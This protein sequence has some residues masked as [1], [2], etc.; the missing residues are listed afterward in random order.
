MTAHALPEDREMCLKSGL[1]D[2]L[3]KPVAKVDLLAALER[4]LMPVMP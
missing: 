2:Y 3:A 1:D 4:W